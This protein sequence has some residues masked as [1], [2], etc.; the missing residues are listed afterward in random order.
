MALWVRT[1]HKD[2]SAWSWRSLRRVLT[3]ERLAPMGD[4]GNGR[5]RAPGHL[6]L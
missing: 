3:S 1:W 4:E 5:D 6:W 2:T